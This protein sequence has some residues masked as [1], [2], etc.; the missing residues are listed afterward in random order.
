MSLPAGTGAVW[1]SECGRRARPPARRRRGSPERQRKAV[2]VRDLQGD[3]E[4]RGRQRQA[5]DARRPR[6]HRAVAA[7]AGRN[8]SPR[9]GKARRRSRSIGRRPVTGEVLLGE[10]LEDAA[11]RVAFTIA[12]S[13][14]A[15]ACA[16]PTP[17]RCAPTACPTSSAHR[18]WGTRTRA[19]SIASTRDY[20][21]S[22]SR[23]FARGSRKVQCRCSKHERRRC[24]ERT[25]RTPSRRRNL[26]RIGSPEGTGL[27]RISLGV[28]ENQALAL[29]V[30]HREWCPVAITNSLCVKRVRVSRLLN[31]R[32]NPRT[33]AR[34]VLA[35]TAVTRAG[36]QRMA[37][38]FHPRS[39]R[40]MAYRPAPPA[41][42]RGR[43]ALRAP[44]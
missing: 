13:A 21:R 12:T 9:A 29:V 10:L 14:E 44:R 30:R 17:P 8:R 32:E 7:G 33:L 15:A 3:R 26:W 27:E 19:C 43:L 23:P 40:K 20:R 22:C 31:T 16:A 42:R 6:R 25:H 34:T 38:T 35:C 5:G 36:T 37:C 11:A 39:A 4:L 41:Q 2:G 1:G 18:R 24:T 28:S